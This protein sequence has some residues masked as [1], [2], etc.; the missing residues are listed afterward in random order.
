VINGSCIGQSIQPCFK[1]TIATP[2]FDRLP[3]LQA[4]ILGDILG[5]LLA[6]GKPP[7]YPVDAIIALLHKHREARPVARRRLNR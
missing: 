5:V 1:R 4:D 3:Q 2:A 7:R 6:A